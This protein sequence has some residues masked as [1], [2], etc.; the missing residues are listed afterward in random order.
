MAGYLK[1]PREGWLSPDPTPVSGTPAAQNRSHP[2]PPTNVG[3]SAPATA[4]QRALP[5]LPL[6]VLLVDDEPALLKTTQRLLE[7]R[8]LTVMGVETAEAAL[9]LLSARAFDL[10]MTDVGLRVMRGPELA[11]RAR[12]LRPD[13]RVLFVSGYDAEEAGIGGPTDGDG[14]L[15]KPFTPRELDDRLRDL[16]LPR[17]GALPLEMAASAGVTARDRVR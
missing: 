11:R 14:F 10:L 17:S 4:R 1:A 13:L 16:L 3:V 12:L 9:E 2:S 7:Q 8:G 5:G 15:G 6:T